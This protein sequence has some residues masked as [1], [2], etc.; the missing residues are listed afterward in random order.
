MLP[1][2]AIRQVPLPTGAL[3]MSSAVGAAGQAGAIPAAELQQLASSGMRGMA[4]LSDLH[5]SQAPGAAGVTGLGD[6]GDFSNVLGRLIQDVNAKQ[7]AANTAIQDL[8]SGGNVSLHQ[9]VL[10]MEEA[11]VSFQ[12]MVEVRN[13]LLESYQELMRMQI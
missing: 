8:N 7:A 11:S 5:P 2:S 3:A 13:K 6:G 10:A 1:L 4:P 12:L 9:A